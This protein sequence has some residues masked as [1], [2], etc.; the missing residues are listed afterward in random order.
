MILAVHYTSSFNSTW[1]KLMMRP[2][3]TSSHQVRPQKYKHKH[4]L[5]TFHTRML[6]LG[7]YSLKTHCRV[8]LYVATPENLLRST[9][10]RVIQHQ[11]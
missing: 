11:R 1:Q 9:C 2:S 8:L 4:F 7:T 10:T 6:M 5:E 3:A